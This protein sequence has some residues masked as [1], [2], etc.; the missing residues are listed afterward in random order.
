MSDCCLTNLGCL[1]IPTSVI[2]TVGQNGANGQDGQDGATGAT[3]PQGPAGFVRVAYSLAPILSGVGASKTFITQPVSATYMPQIQG[4]S[5][6]LT[7]NVRTD[8]Y[9]LIR[10]GLNSRLI[11]I[12]F[13]NQECII[14]NGNLL[15]VSV[16]KMET[17]F[18]VEIIRSNI[19]SEAYARVSVYGIDFT[20]NSAICY[21]ES[22]LLTGLNFFNQND[23]VIYGFQ[24]DTNTF[25][26]S[27]LTVD[28]IT[29][30]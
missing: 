23:F 4:S 9:P 15:P 20:E 12:R 10:D 5:L 22:N 6:L 19:A 27:T 28:K 29:A 18:K 26:F 7:F 30:L 1:Q 24:N 21:N 8:T 2:S 3:G 25:I 17:Q 14:G 11:G 16:G 13:G